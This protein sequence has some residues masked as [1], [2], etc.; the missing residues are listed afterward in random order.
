VTAGKLAVQQGKAVAVEVVAALS[1]SAKRTEFAAV[2]GVVVVE[3]K[4]GIATA[5][6]SVQVS[7][8]FNVGVTFLLYSNLVPAGALNCNAIYPMPLE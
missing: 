6:R 5:L 8:L 3:G 2:S 4:I 7:N 1:K